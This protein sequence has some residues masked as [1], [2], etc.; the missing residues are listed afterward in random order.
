MG[1]SASGASSSSSSGSTNLEKRVGR[2]LLLQVLL[3]VEQRHIEQVHR[4]VQARIDLQFLAQ[5]RRLL[6]TRS[7]RLSTPSSASENRERRRAVNVGPR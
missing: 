6:K 7:H 4:L 5:A 2:Q 3:Q 1:S